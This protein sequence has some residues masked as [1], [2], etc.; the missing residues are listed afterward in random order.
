MTSGASLSVIPKDMP[1]R[2]INNGVS[3]VVCGKTVAFACHV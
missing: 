2:C 1:A 3:V